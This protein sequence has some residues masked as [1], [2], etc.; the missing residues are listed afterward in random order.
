MY[1]TRWLDVTSSG[2][3]NLG[4]VLD[5]QVSACTT[6]CQPNQPLKTLYN[7][8]GFAN[9]NCPPLLNANAQAVTA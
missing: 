5:S 3:L 9:S 1:A 2:R 7:S 4:K 6:G 8:A